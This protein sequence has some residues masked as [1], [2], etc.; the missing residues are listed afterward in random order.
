MR[1]RTPADDARDWAASVAETVRA[2]PG[3][4]AEALRLIYEERLTQVDVA[5]RL[6]MTIGETKQIVRAAILAIAQR[7]TVAR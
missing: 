1:L 5:S 7:P 4:Q 6:G 3:R 2:L